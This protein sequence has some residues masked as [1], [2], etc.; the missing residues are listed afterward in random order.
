MVFCI[1]CR[2][3]ISFVNL[4]CS[5]CGAAF[6]KSCLSRYL[7][8]KRRKAKQCCLAHF[9]E[10]LPAGT[11]RAQ[12]NNR[13]ASVVDGARG[14][15]PDLDDRNSS[16]E[17]LHS[18][19]P[20]TS[21]NFG[22]PSS[23]NPIANMAPVPPNWES[24]TPSQQNAVL[25]DRITAGEER[26]VAKI[27]ALQTECHEMRQ[28]ITTLESDNSAQRTE[29]EQIKELRVRAPE[30]TELKVIGIPLDTT[31]S[32]YDIF[33]KILII[34][35]LE[36]HR[37]DILEVRQLQYK[38]PGNQDNASAQP[39]QNIRNAP[40]SITL[41][42]HLKSSATRDFILRAKRRHGAIT[43]ADLVPGSAPDIIG[44]Y[45]MVSSLINDLRVQ[46]KDRANESG[47]KHVWISRNNVFVRK[48]DGS[49]PIAIVT[50]SDLD[51]MI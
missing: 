37:N 8:L 18:P 6:H 40:R 33:V 2:K 51:K 28:R 43:Y 31:L 9:K 1:G 48:T 24:M 14:I 36:S 27:D 21:G 41:V 4:T 19:Q 32:H 47:Y 15:S 20:S 16:L 3:N 50:E 10:Y 38:H 35:G 34:L 42:A 29:T 22:P 23:S 39:T 11:N 30:S 25:F 26:L 45:E 49:K 44:L 13:R 46:A 5:Q 7:S 12:S 17:S